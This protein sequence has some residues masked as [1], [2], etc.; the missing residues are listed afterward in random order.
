MKNNDKTREQLL[1]ELVKSNKRIAEL[2]K[3]ETEHKQIEQTLSHEQDLMQALFENHH[4]FFYFKD[5]EVRF[6]RVSKRFCDFFGLSMED[7][8]GK[9]DLELFPE[10]VAK[11]TYSEDLHIIKTG[12]PL[13]NKEESAGGVCV[14]TTKIPWFDKEGNIIGLLGISR[15]I[16]ERK[17]AEEKYKDL[18]EKAGIAILIDDLDGNIVFSNQRFHEIF[19]YS[20]DEMKKKSI[21][22]LV[23]PKDVSEVMKNHRSRLE[24]KSV[25]SRYE[26]RGVKKDGSVIDL[27][28][29]VVL[30]KEGSSLIGTRSYL[31]DITERKQAEE[32]LR[33]AEANIKNTFDISPGLIC[34]ANANTGYFTEC[35]PAVTQMLG[36]SIEEFTSRPFREFIHPDDRQKTV[37]EIT[38][39]LKGKPVANFENRYQ[40]KDGSYK[41]LAWQATAADKN[42]KVYAVATDINERKQ[43]EEVLRQYE[44]I[45]SSST[46]MLALLDKQYCYIAA[47]KAYVNG[48][49]LTHEQLIGNTVAQV[50]GENIFNTVIKPYADRCLGGEEVNYQDWSDFPGYGRRYMD[51]TYYPYYDENNKIV[52]FAVNGRNITER[53]QVEE[54]LRES[55]QQYRTLGETVPYGVWL[56]DAI[57]YC[58][59]V[60]NSFLEMVDMTMEQVQEFGWLHLLP[61]KDV[62]PTKEHWLHCVQT[63]E[64]FE[65][66]HRFRTKHGNYRNVLAIGRPI[67]DDTGKITKWIGLNLDIT[68]RKKAEEEIKNMKES[69]VMLN[70]RFEDI[71]ENERKL[72]SRELHD[73]LGQSLTAL[74]L[75]INFLSKKIDSDSKEGA[76]LKDINKLLNSTIKDVQRISSELHPAMLDDLGLHA[77]TEW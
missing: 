34:V 26:F 74:K 12:T 67:K 3:S 8:L 47:N 31:W 61:P 9:T 49:K 17:Q 56:T 25:P 71:S 77:T 15:D 39:Q 10:E 50:F 11:Q 73:Q 41:W 45:V 20:S 66:E 21:Q 16:T 33:K 75:D 57:G 38:K 35:N 27:E 13:V 42:G 2:E 52:G 46:D 4:D 64:N 24:G 72:I 18:V 65:R 51:A 68:E 19:G 23:F 53:K 40:S 48:F 28:T 22:N 54:N 63:G 58:T 6:H 7:I 30:L 59:Y 36:F 1:K 43:E 60:S 14:L 44:H 32:K 55:E 70:S 62:E 29:D 5:S 69:L 76:K 37:D